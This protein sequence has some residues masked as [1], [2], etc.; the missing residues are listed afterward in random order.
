MC[1]W[2]HQPGVRGWSKSRSVRRCIARRFITASLRAFVVVVNAT[3]PS[4][5][6]LE[7]AS[8]KHSDAASVAYPAPHAHRANRHPIS[9]R[10][11]TGHSKATRPRPVKPA[12]CPSISTAHSPNWTSLNDASALSMRASDS[13]R[14]K[15]AGKNLVTSGSAFISANGSRSLDFQRRNVT[16]RPF[17]PCTKDFLSAPL[18]SL[19]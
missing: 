16:R 15:A 11:S 13:S 10:D 2:P 8:S 14:D 1:R 18:L 9:T 19:A 17:S 7:N 6:S 12:R 3:T 4:R 5:P